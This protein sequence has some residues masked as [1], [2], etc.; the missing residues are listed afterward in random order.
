MTPQIGEYWYLAVQFKTIDS[1]KE[2][3]SNQQIIAKC[4]DIKEDKPI[5]IRYG[6]FGLISIYDNNN[7][8]HYKLICKMIDE[9]KEPVKVKWYWKLLGY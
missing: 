4:I 9:P 8:F 7:G 2:F 3:I 5:F 6:V 1:G